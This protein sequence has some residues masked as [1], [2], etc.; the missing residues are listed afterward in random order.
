MCEAEASAE[1][2]VNARSHLNI[3][4]LSV[5]TRR[6]TFGGFD[7]GKSR[8]YAQPTRKCNYLEK[9]FK[10]C[11]PYQSNLKYSEP[12]AGPQCARHPVGRDKVV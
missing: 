2:D 8:E 12:N 7:K 3:P 6:C 1:L 4:H 5:P 10:L 11:R 9:H